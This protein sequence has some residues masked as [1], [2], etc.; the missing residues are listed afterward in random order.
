MTTAR[1]VALITGASMGLGA[2]FARV[3][4]SEGYD[5]VLTARNGERMATLK[6]EVEN[7]H[8]GTAHVLVADLTDPRAPL[9]IHEHLRRSG[10]EVDVLVN[11]AGFGM[12]GK[13]HE[14]DLQTELDMVQV[15]IIALMHL[16]KLFARDMVARRSGRIVN[17]AS[18][19][20]FQPGPLQSVYY[21]SKAFVLSF[22][23]AIGNEL[24]GTG[25]TVTALCP[26]PTPT[27]FQERANVGN[28]R[29][30]RLLMRLSPETVVRAGYNGMKRGQPVVVP[31]VLNNI[32]AFMV[33]LTPRSLVTHMVRRI[34]THPRS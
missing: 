32:L 2:E 17:V 5:V 10:I 4:A 30:L 19:A 34:Q 18:T 16:T 33:R 27:G 9:A 29:G 22:S 23:E 8:G 6:K 21:A 28:L 12:Y 7:L 1:P 3:L 24:R 11:N 13:F 26:G 25:V 31:G 20:A 15:N 14:S